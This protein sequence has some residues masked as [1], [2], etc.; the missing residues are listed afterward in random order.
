VYETNFN[1]SLHA[2]FDDRMRTE[3]SHCELVKA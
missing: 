1:F 2:L 3:I